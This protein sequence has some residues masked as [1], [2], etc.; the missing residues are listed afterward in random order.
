[1]QYDNKGLL[2]LR[3]RDLRLCG[4]CGTPMA[5]EHDNLDHEIHL[6][7]TTLDDPLQ[8]TPERHV[9]VAEKLPWLTVEDDLPRHLSSWEV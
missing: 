6:Y 3:S 4:H 9:F 1:M 5:Y 8:Y 2:S 7:A